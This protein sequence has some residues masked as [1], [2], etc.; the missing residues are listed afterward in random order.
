MLVGG[1]E[2]S[3]GVERQPPTNN[4]APVKAT[5]TGLNKMNLVDERMVS[6]AA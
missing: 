3:R 1:D 2:K 5:A 6:K 4:R